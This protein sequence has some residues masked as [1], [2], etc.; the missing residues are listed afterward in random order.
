MD[1]IQVLNA[2][3]LGAYEYVDAEWR[4]NSSDAKVNEDCTSHVYL[5]DAICCSNW[6]KHRYEQ[7]DSCVTVDE[8]T[9]KDEQYVNHEQEDDR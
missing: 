2:L 7:K 5:V 4:R 6:C 8:H 3:E 1:N 9:T